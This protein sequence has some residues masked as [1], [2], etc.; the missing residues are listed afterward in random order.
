MF[1]D[2]SHPL[3][4]AGARPRR[5]RRPPAWMQDYVTYPAQQQVGDAYEQQQSYPSV[6]RSVERIARMTSLTPPP[7][8]EQWSVFE[9]ARARNPYEDEYS[10]SLPSSTPVHYRQRPAAEDT[11]ATVALLHRVLDDNQRMQRQMMEMQQRL[12]TRSTPPPPLSSQMPATAQTQVYNAPLTQDHSQ[13]LPPPPPAQVFSF[14]SPTDTNEYW[15]PPPPPV[16]DDFIKPLPPPPPPQTVVSELTG[17]VRGMTVTPQEQP[18]HLADLHQTPLRVQ[19]PEYCS[20][21]TPPRYESAHIRPLPPPQHEMVYRGPKPTIPTFTKGDPREFARLKVALENLLPE[22][23]TERFKY[24]ILLDHLKHEDALLIAD[25]YINSAQPYTDTMSSLTERY[26][27]PHQLALRKI[28]DLM[29]SSSIARGDTAGFKR[30]ALRVRALVGLLEQLGESGQTELCCGSHVTR[31]LSKLPQDMRAEFKRFLYPMRV[32]IPSLLH[33]SDWLNYELKIQETVYESLH[34]EVKSSSESKTA[35]RHDNK[36]N[37]NTSIFHTTNKPSDAPPTEQVPAIPKRS[38]FCPYCVNTLHYLDQCGNFALLTVEQRSSWIKSNRRCWRCG[39]SHQAAQCRLK[40]T[41]PKCK[42]KHLQALHDVNAKPPETP[43]SPVSSTNEVLYLDRRSGC[44]QVLLKISRVLLRNG[45][46]SLETYAVLDDGSERT[47]LLPAAAQTLKLIGEPED[48]ALRTVRQDIKV[49]HGASVSFSISPADQPQKTFT[50]KGAFTAEPLSL[51]EHSYSVETLQRKY[52]HLRGLPL[53]TMNRVRPLLLIGSDYPHLITPVAPVRLGRHG[54]PAAVRTTLGWTLQGPIKN[55]KQPPTTQ[56]CF[57]ISTMSPAVEILQNVEKLW[58][59][60]ILPYRSEKL[61]VRSRQDQEAMQL[62]E[63]K[64]TRV[65]IQGVQRYAT[66]LL[67]VKNMPQL[68]APKEAVLTNL[69]STEKR[70]KRDPEK[71]AAYC[72]EI[73]KL[74]SAGYVV[75]VTEEELIS[76]KSRGDN[77]NQLLL[78]GP[79]LT[80]SLLGVLLRFREYA[81]AVCSDIKGMFHQ[82]RLLPEDKT[83]LCFLWR[84]LQTEKPPSIYVW[85]VLPFGTTCS[86]CCATFALQKHVFDHSQEEHPTAEEA[87]HLVDKLK[88]LLAAGGFDLRQ[89]ASNKPETI[90]HLP[91][92]ARSESSELWL[93][94]SSTD[95]QELALGL[96]WLCN[97]DTLRYKYQLL[98]PPAPTMRNIYRVL[99]RLYDPLGFIVPF[100]TR[101]KVLV[102]RL[103]DKQ[104]EWD[105][106]SLPEDILQPW[107]EWEAELPHLSQVTL[108]R[109][110]V[111]P[112]INTT[113]CLRDIHVFADASERAYGSV[114]YLRSEDTNGLVEVSF[115]TARSRVAPKK[116]QSMPRLELCAALTAAQLAALL[117]HELTLSIDSIFLWTDSTTVLTWLH[118]DSC[119]FK[120]FVG[121][122]VAE[123]QELTDPHSWRYVNS[124]QNPADDV[125]RGKTLQ[126][127]SNDGRWRHGPAFL[128]Q[129]P[130]CWPVQPT[131]EEPEEDPEL[132][133]PAISCLITTTVTATLQS[134]ADQCSSFTDLIETVALSHHG[135]APSPPT[136]TAA[137]Y[138]NAERDILQQVQQENFPEEYNLLS[139]NKP[140]PATCRLLT[141]APEFDHAAG[142]IRVGGRL[143]RSSHLEPETIHPVVLDPHH[144][145]TQ[146][147][148]QDTDRAL[149]HP[150]SERLFAELRRKYWILR[151]REAVKRH[152]HSCPECQ[153]WRAMPTVPKMSDLPE[154]RLRLLKPPFFSTG[155]DCF[156]PFTVKVGRRLEKR[157]GIVFKCLT[158]RAVHLDILSSLDH[159]S[160]LMALRRF[161]ARRGK[162]AELL[163]DQ[164]TNFKGGER[165]LRE[166]F[167]TVQPSLR[168]HLA[169]HQIQFKFNPP[170]APHFGDVADP[171]PVTPNLLLMG[172]LD[173]SLPQAVYEDAEPLSRRRWRHSQ[174]LADQFWTHFIRSYLPTLQTRSKWHKDP[175]QLQVGTIVMVMDPQLPRALWPVG[176][177]TSVFPGRDGRIRAAAVQVKDKTYTRPVARLVA[178]PAMP[179]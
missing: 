127:L 83:L 148:I 53:P 141:L 175:A 117:Q 78:P 126:E 59:L 37:K 41:C 99:A 49:M 2:Q 16:S 46:N 1:S 144:K 28:A 162:P 132:R 169:K 176:L 75:K 68:K 40:V 104:R 157:W 92:E 9:G 93:Q 174:V 30:F 154:A 147:I 159:D 52:R 167:E 62:L 122:R 143:R 26:G 6:E 121:T 149:C 177:V 164:G 89:W 138:Q 96:R 31:L 15:P 84:N 5:E 18:Q 47:I 151:G 100:T 94:E 8:V 32:T 54:G 90:K 7:P 111:S 4:D 25:S 130:E 39:R 123:I 178:L 13:L 128:Q 133:K 72:N 20:P 86:P 10:L 97:S 171:D 114:A 170:N 73:D 57:H 102:Q 153:R 82:V 152:Q 14:T 107:L 108:P 161:I 38:A 55:V 71:A 156:G 145:V 66:P 136:L 101:A 51:A 118:S 119:R 95:P 135:A 131:K 163:S 109:C 3:H 69:R 61:V 76:A 124:A 172:R 113:N 35:R 165:E 50:I 58:Q 64:T 60:D 80:S 34:S 110:Y 63:T 43:L 142:L 29:E 42:G 103:W 45:E 146:L 67:R 33:F 91:K 36:G 105:D 140:I 150:G 21:Y 19:T 56:Q 44:N 24:Q 155:M 17:L 79:T 70:L 85:Q 116:Q 81:V 134:Q 168:D 112:T 160:F 139:T 173:P 137:D 22:D 48:L 98:E 115:L 106:P 158:T 74:E 166:A 120:V 87:K 179:D 27:Q 125:T 11:S 23:A 88:A 77:L 65:D 129:S 12:D